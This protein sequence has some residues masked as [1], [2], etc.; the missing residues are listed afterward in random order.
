[1]NLPLAYRL[2]YEV[3]GLTLAVSDLPGMAPLSS[4]EPFACPPFP[5][6]K[7]DLSVE[8]QTYPLDAP[9][10]PPEEEMDLVSEDLVNRLFLWAGKLVK[11]TAMRERDPRCM[12]TLMDIAQ[13]SHADVFMPEDWL[14]YDAYGNAFLFEKM[15]LPH[16]ALMLHCSLVE[17]RGKGIAFTA[18][19]QTGKSTQARLW[20]E[21]RGADVLNGDRAI[22]RAM[23]EGI[24][25]YGSPWAGSSDLFINRRAPL[26]AIV[27]LEQGPE[28]V[29]RKIGHAEALRWFLMGTS[30]PIWEPALLEYGMNTLDRI[31][32]ETPLFLLSCRPDE[33]AVE[34]LEACLP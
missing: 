22:L 32:T 17:W 7:A 25:A 34:A 15:L 12:W 28:N 19:S 10:V 2:F 1:V 27:V 4:F 13:P 3:A 29:C 26:S 21:H 11:R 6:E 23:P 8:I 9:P 14:D 18:P 16:G 31:V 5:L 33:G 30:L 20:Q 24:F